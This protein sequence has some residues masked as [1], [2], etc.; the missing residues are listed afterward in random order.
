MTV[1]RE[2]TAPH[3]AALPPLVTESFDVASTPD[4]LERLVV[5]TREYG[6]IFRIYAPGRKSD[7]WVINN[8]GDIRRAL[9]TNH[10]N[11]TKGFGFDRIRLLLGNGII[12]TEGELWKRQRR[13]MQPLF[14]RRVIET[15]AALVDRVVNARLVRWEG[16]AARGETIDVTEEMSQMTLDIV[17]SS[18]F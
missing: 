5:L 13:M 11:Y 16:H 2:H 9:V 1:P 4:S 14:T 18:I 8:P 15:Y 17:L 3:T 12:V 6:D 7:T 10:R